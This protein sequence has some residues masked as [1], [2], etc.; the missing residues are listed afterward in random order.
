MSN[1]R[2]SICFCPFKST[3]CTS[4][5]ADG[6]Q[7]STIAQ[8]S[9]FNFTHTVA[10]FCS[11]QQVLTSD[12]MCRGDN[13]E[14]GL[15]K[16]M[17]GAHRASQLRAQLIHFGALTSCRREPR[18]ELDSRG[19]VKDVNKDSMRNF[20]RGGA[21]ALHVGTDAVDA[22]RPFWSEDCSVWLRCV[23]KATW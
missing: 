9:K 19:G 17:N 14:I 4:I 11:S 20:A 21:R 12:E 5:A 10:S 15:L 7:F 3:F 13:S 23:R 2:D 6:A 1:P 22:C 8:F 16:A 18:R